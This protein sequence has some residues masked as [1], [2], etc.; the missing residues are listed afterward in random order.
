MSPPIRILFD[1][2]AVARRVSELAARIAADHGGEPP[3]ILGIRNGAVPFMMDLLRLLPASWRPDLVFDFL[4]ATSYVGSR[5]AGVRLSGDLAVDLEG[6]AVLLVD[7]IVDTGETIQAVLGHLRRMGPSRVQVCALLD[8]PSRR[9]V[10]VPIDYLGFEVEDVF[11]VGYG[12]DFD[13]RYRGL[14]C[15][16]ALEDAP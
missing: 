2:A 3:V 11:V 9:R 15:I 16:G 8:K 13:Q 7:D 12:M 5:S 6:R 10:P 14:R 1:E 4:D